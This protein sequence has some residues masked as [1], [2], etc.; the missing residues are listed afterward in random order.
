[1]SFGFYSP[2]AV[3]QLLAFV[4][5]GCETNSQDTT[6]HLPLAQIAV[7]LDFLAEGVDTR[8]RGQMGETV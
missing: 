8:K 3:R 1:M 4:T 7:L 6:I 2:S 5:L